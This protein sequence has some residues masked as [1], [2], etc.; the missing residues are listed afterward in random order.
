MGKQKNLHNKY[1]SFCH[2]LGV[3]YHQ[4]DGVNERILDDDELTQ[5]E[6]KVKDMRVLLAKRLDSALQLQSETKK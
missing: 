4:M 1:E 2:R 5:L 3:T 6:D